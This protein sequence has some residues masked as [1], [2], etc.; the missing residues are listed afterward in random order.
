MN[1]GKAFRSKLF[2]KFA[3]RHA[4][5]NRRVRLRCATAH[6]AP[7]HQG[8]PG[9]SARRLCHRGS[10]PRRLPGS[11]SPRPAGCDPAPSRAQGASTTA[12]AGHGFVP[13]PARRSQPRRS[14]PG[15]RCELHR[16][17]AHGGCTDIAMGVQ[18][19]SVRPPAEG[20]PHVRAVGCR[21]RG[22]PLRAAPCSLEPSRWAGWPARCRFGADTPVRGQHSPSSANHT[23]AP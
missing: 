16:R 12:A 13:P 11:A 21:G 5:D 1:A 19:A 7:L 10:A 2:H 3:Q 9:R 20:I 17:K 8:P 18:V 22:W 23:R 14:A 4:L 15:F 6:L